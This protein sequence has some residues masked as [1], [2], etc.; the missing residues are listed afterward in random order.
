M[1]VGIVTIVDLIRTRH[2][3]HI[4]WIRRDILDNQS[5]QEPK[6]QRKINVIGNT[7]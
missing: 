7:F 3:N 1:V 2:R 6:G 5:N 4:D